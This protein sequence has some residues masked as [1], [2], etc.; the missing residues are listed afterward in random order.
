MIN[1]EDKIINEMYEAVMAVSPNANIVSEYVRKPQSFPHVS[2]IEQYN[3]THQRAATLSSIDHASDLMY[4]VNV[5]SNLTVGKKN[6]V[7][8]IMSAICDRFS[9]LGF[10]RNSTMVTPNVEDST[11]YR[12]TARFERVIGDM[13]V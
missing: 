7:K 4:E 11:I 10:L 13:E 2:I 5:Y 8:T 6:E 1:I 9:A 3:N 12:M